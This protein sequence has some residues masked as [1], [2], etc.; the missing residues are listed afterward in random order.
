LSEGSF[1]NTA[2]VRNV[3]EG[4]PNPNNNSASDTVV[5]EPI[6]DV[7]MTG[8][9]VTP[10]TVRAGEV[11]TYVLSFRN[12]GPSPALGVTV[13]DQFTFPGGDSGVTVTQITSSKAGSSCSIAAGAVLTPGSSNFSCTIGTLANGETQ[14]ITLLV[15]PNFQAGNPARSFG[16]LARVNTT[17]VENPAGG[18]NGNNER[19]ATLAVTAAAVDLL[20][21]KTDRVGAVNFD[22][23]AYTAGSSF[24]AYQVSVNNSGPSYATGAQVTETM[25]PRRASAC[26]L[27]AMSPPSAAVPATRCRCA[28]SPT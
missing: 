14:T 19:S 3:N 17:S 7:E 20:V 8:K 5:I 13:N 1:T 9:S 26:V 23:V 12:N 27:S 18:D 10:G 11:A 16:N 2:T 24:L 28:A 15:R 22:P 25:T 6:A 4:D 21:N